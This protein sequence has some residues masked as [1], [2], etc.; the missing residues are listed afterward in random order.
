V[1]LLFTPFSLRQ[2]TMRNRI[3]MSPMAMWSAGEDGVARDWHFAHYG[4]RATGGVGLIV[5][6]ATAVEPR[7]RISV[8]DLGL[9]DDGQIGRLAHIVEF[10]HQRGAAIGPQLAHAGRKAFSPKRGVGPQT[11]VAP[12]AIP[13][14]EDWAVP[15][16][17][18]GEQ[19]AEIVAAFR[20]AA[21]RAIRVGFDVIEVHAAHGYLLHEFLSPLSNRRDDEYGG[22]LENRSRMLLR[23][24][25]AIREVWPAAK[26]LLVRVSATDWTPGGLTVGDVAQVAGWLKAHGVD[27]VDC[28]SGGILPTAPAK[29]APGYQVPFAAQVRR[30]AGV[31][32]M[33]VGLITTPELAEE[34]VSNERADMVA[35]GRELLRS[36]YWPLHAAHTLKADVTWPWQYERSRLQ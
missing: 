7:G 4:A 24:V 1:S 35:L 5:M 25:D 15:Q 21:E 18:T 2:L 12:S 30:E 23:V 28:S 8:N 19:M 17:L 14:D 9:W 36:P 10:C 16:E 13:A 29:I 32:T 20:A 31:P 3:A 27:L 11:P 33:A 22:S 26:P 34:I 6:E